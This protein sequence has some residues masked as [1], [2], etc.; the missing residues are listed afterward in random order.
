[1]ILHIRFYQKQ[2]IT[3]ATILYLLTCVEGL[4]LSSDYSFISP[5]LSFYYIQS[6]IVNKISSALQLLT[7]QEGDISVNNWP[8]ADRAGVNI[9]KKRAKV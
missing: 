2:R 8:L 3:I 4:H 6:V 7:F 5:A 9:V 1:M